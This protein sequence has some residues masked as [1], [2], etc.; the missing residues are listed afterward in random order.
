MWYYCSD[1]RDRYEAIFETDIHPSITPG[2]NFWTSTSRPYSTL[3]ELVEGECIQ[4]EP[5]KCCGRLVSAHYV[6]DVKEEMIR[7]NL[8]FECNIWD[9]REVNENTMIV[10]EGMYTVH[11]MGSTGICGSKGFG[12]ALF[13]FIKDG[14]TIESDNVWFGGDVPPEWR[15]KFPNNAS[16]VQGRVPVEM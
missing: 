2:G 10:D 6:Q 14:K 12:G 16:I 11:P 5:C 1:H 15:H 8:C 13:T 3:D 4:P 7:K 9:E